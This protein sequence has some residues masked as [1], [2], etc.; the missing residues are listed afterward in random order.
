V[1]VLVSVGAKI[2][3]MVVDAVSDV[4][5]SLRRRSG[6]ADLARSTPGS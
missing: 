2:V 5:I 3:G 4:L 6:D 1:I